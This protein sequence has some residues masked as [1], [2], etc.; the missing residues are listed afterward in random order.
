M[1]QFGK[2]FFFFFCV[3]VFRAFYEYESQEFQ[4]HKR[5]FEGQKEA[6][7]CLFEV[8]LGP[9][10]PLPLSTRGTIVF[11][12]RNSKKSSFFGAK[13]VAFRAFYEYE[14]FSGSQKRVLRAKKEAK[15]C[16][17]EVFLEPVRPLPLSTRGTI[18][19]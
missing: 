9:V 15:S 8:F 14:G 3:G 12:A 10:R 4:G 19:F 6:K 2:N 1:D 16:L 7:S 13:I 18:G 11:K 17:F 5:G